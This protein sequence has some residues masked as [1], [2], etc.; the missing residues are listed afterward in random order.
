MR[1]DLEAQVIAKAWADEGFKKTLIS[2]PHSAVEKEFGIKLPSS[3]NLR[4]VEESDD[5]LYLVVPRK[6]AAA[7]RG[8]LSDLELETV[9][10]GKAGT[11]G[12]KERNGAEYLKE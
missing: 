5:N 6:S 2:S 7:E 10:G 9:A 8:E 12:S 4:V 11:M 1:K 3:I